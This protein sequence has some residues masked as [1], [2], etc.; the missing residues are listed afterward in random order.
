MDCEQEQASGCVAADT[1]LEKVRSLHP[2]RANCKV[3][4]Y[5]TELSPDTG[6]TAEDN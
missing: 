4:F 5:Q 3:Y 2:S 1:G 6:Q